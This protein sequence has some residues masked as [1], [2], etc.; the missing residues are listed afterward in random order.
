MMENLFGDTEELELFSQNDLPLVQPYGVQLLLSDGQPLPNAE[1]TL[2]TDFF[3]KQDSDKLFTELLN[4]TKWRQDKMKLYGKEIDLPRQ[5]A[6]YGDNDKDYTF[7]G[8]TMNPESWTPMLLDIKGKVEEAAGATF[9][10]V[11]LNHYR[12]GS[13]SIS[14]HTDAERELGKN[15]VIASVT[16]GDAR[17]FMLRHINNK[18]IKTEVE[19]THGSLLVMGGETQHF[20]QHQ[21][22]KTKSNVESRINL[23]FRQ[24]KAK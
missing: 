24:I 8:I 10:S 1:A 22:P 20:W 16:F 13:D 15:P 21:V 17:R 23:T 6:W 9:N 2:Y 18:D 14:W 5:T 4:G 3:S 19:L 11:L 7:S 12:S